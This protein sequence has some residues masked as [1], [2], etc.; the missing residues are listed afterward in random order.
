MAADVGHERSRIRN[1]AQTEERETEDEQ[2][3]TNTKKI[4]TSVFGGRTGWME[5]LI[6]F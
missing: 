5:G 1:E 4:N 6:L 3:A 2:R